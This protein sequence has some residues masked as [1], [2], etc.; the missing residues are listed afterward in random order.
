VVVEALI[1]FLMQ[2]VEEELVDLEK[3]NLQQHLTLHHL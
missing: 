3:I 1:I 2:Q